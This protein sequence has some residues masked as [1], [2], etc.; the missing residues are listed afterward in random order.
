MSEGYCKEEAKVCIGLV[1]DRVGRA[2]D[3][4]DKVLG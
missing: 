3:R 2:L 1:G 4:R